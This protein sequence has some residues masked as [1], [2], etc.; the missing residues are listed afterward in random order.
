MG[1]LSV[2]EKSRLEALLGMESGYVLQFSNASFERFIK[3]V[4]GI[5]IYKGKGYEEYVSKANKLRQIWSNESDVVV[6]NLI[7]A[8]M[9]KYIDCKKQTNEFHLHDEHD[10]NEMRIVADRLLENA[11]KLDIPMQKEVTLKTLQEDINNALS[12]NQPTLV[13]DRLHTFSTIFLRKICKQYEITVVD[14]KGKNLPLHSL[15]GMLKKH[16]E[17]NPVF[18][19]EFVPLAI[20]NIIVLFDRFNTIRNEQSYAHDNT[21]LCNI[22]SEFVVRSMINIISF[23]DSI[24]RYRK[25]N[26]APPASEGIEIEN[27]DLPF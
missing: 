13:L 1:S 11:I 10:V 25:I 24:E 7:N 15:A 8:L 6:G 12:R 4:C 23:I 22:E 14:N 16:Y 18:D 27:E 3:D 5:D 2:R 19:S 9:D 26:S 17:Q 20:Q 21:I